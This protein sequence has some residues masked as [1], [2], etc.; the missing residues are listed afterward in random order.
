MPTT[1]G[2]YVRISRLDM[3]VVLGRQLFLRCLLHYLEGI[4]AWP[5]VLYVRTYRKDWR[6]IWAW[7]RTSVPRT[8]VV[9]TIF[10]HTY[11]LYLVTVFFRFCALSSN[12]MIDEN[13]GKTS[14]EL[15]F[16]VDCDACF[17]EWGS[18]GLHII[19]VLQSGTCIVLPVSPF[20]LSR[21]HTDKPYTVVTYAYM[22]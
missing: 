1:D 6:V 18:D 21:V 13:Q 3:K 15:W 9:H 17:N 8:T 16:P 11:Q 10:G 12:I 2:K 19:Y 14:K 4:K 20:F 7:I 22:Y 5:Y